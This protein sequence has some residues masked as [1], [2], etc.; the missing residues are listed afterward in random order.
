MYLECKQNI[1]Q[2]DLDKKD[3]KEAIDYMIS[4]DYIIQK[5]IDDENFYSKILY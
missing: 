3:F 2:F 5:V 1:K 4:R